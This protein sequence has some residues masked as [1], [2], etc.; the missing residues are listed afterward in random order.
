[1][2][3]RRARTVR[4]LGRLSAVCCVTTAYMH[5]RRLVL[6]RRYRIEP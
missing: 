3:V 4:N 1:V 2:V 6:P 5:G